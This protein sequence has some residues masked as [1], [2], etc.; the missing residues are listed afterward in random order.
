MA[1]NRIGTLTNLET[2]GTYDLLIVKAQGTYPEGKISFGFYD[3]PMKI[4]GLQ[5]VAQVFLKILMTTKGS[6]VFYPA[7][8][9]DFPELTTGANT[10][11]DDNTLLAELSASI[12]D[13]VNQTINSLNVNTTD[14]SSCL[15]SVDIL[16]MDRI[17][18]GIVLYLQLK[19]LAG[20][21]AAI[22]LP[23]PEFGL[24]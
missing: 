19:T 21:F 10:I 18:E 12:N 13:A 7:M 8:G 4:T 23:F 20:E 6:D 9:T 15:Y 3:V 22:S 17:S 5:K 2:G 1:S 11:S 24:N 14:E 16:G